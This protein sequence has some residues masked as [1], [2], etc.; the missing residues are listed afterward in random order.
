MR[1]V[2]PPETRTVSAL[3]LVVSPAGWLCDHHG[4][5]V[6]T[7]FNWLPPGETE[8]AS[9]CGRIA[10]SWPVVRRM[11][12]RALPY[13]DGRLRPP[14]KRDR[15]RWRLVPRSPIDVDVLSSHSFQWGCSSH[16]NTPLCS[17]TRSERITHGEVP[18][19]SVLLSTPDGN[20]V[21]A[22]LPAVSLPAL[23]RG[24]GGALGPD[25]GGTN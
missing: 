8:T 6:L 11:G 17:Y 21:H 7:S 23:Q 24:D 22:P 1:R 16:S 5:S 13:I 18:H 2:Q 10:S 12:D 14:D 20:S 9:S 4:L 15:N 25:R 19:Q 3:N